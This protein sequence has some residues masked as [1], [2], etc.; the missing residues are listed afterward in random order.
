MKNSHYHLASPSV[1][2]FFIDQ[3]LTGF[4]FLILLGLLVFSRKSKITTT[5][6]LKV[7]I[8]FIVLNEGK[9]ERGDGKVKGGGKI[10]ITRRGTIRE[11]R[12]RRRG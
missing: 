2:L 9:G 10:K 11:R 4:S 3:R 1:V 6:I 12:R 5:W 7:Q 8:I